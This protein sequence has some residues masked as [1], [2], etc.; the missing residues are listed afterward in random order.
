MVKS[1]LLKVKLQFHLL[2]TIKRLEFLKTVSIRERD[3]ALLTIRKKDL[4]MKLI[5]ERF[6]AL[7]N[8]T[9]NQIEMILRESAIVSEAN[10]KILLRGKKM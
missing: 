10:T 6:P 1:L 9:L 2:P 8:T 5:L 7:E 3:T 4:S